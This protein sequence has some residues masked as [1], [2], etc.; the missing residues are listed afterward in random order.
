MLKLTSKYFFIALIC[1]LLVGCTA[2]LTNRQPYREYVNKDLT[3]KRPV[4]LCERKLSNITLSHGEVPL[5]RGELYEIMMGEREK[6]LDKFENDFCYAKYTLNIGAA[7]KIG[8]FYSW[9]GD[10]YW[11][12]RA[13][14]EIYLK[15]LSKEVPFEYDWPQDS[16]GNL[17]RA[18]WEEDTVSEQRNVGYMGTEYR[19]KQ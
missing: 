10:G 16:K 17:L 5:K 13:V 15:D 19:R 9:L 2:T 4:A 18:P 6:V 11:V 8:K 12:I 14:G 7:L 1:L 3:L